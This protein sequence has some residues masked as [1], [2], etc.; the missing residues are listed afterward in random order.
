MKGK[1]NMMLITITL[2]KVEPITVQPEPFE[3]SK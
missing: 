2:A 1:K 3:E